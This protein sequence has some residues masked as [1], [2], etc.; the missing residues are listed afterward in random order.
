MGGGAG[1]RRYVRSVSGGTKSAMVGMAVS[2]R[3]CAERPRQMYLGVLQETKV[4]EVI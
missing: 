1:R 2:I 3:R 4:T